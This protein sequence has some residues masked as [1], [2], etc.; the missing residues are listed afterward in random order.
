[1][2][3]LYTWHEWSPGMW[4]L[5]AGFRSVANAKADGSWYIHE[6]GSCDHA[7]I[8]GGSGSESNLYDAKKAAMQCAVKM[9]NQYMA[10]LR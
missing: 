3:K 7:P 2:S 6:L 5:I 10:G 8:P 4:S 9:H 1:M